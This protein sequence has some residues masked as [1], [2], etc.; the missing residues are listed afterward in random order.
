MFI[1][2]CVL[3][4]ATLAAI[5]KATNGR[6]T[7]VIIDSRNR[8]SLSKF[9]ACGWT[10]LVVAA[11]AT[12]GAFNVA[13]CREDALEFD[14]Q[15]DLLIAM[16]IS[17]VSLTATPALLSL[18]TTQQ[19]SQASL[20]SA[21]N[22]LA[23]PPDDAGTAQPATMTNNGNV[24]S[25]ISIGDA[26]LTDLFM[27]DEVG[28][29]NSP[30]LGKIQQFLITLLLLAIYAAQVFKKFYGVDFINQLPDLQ[31][32]FLWLMGVSH[33]SYLAYKAAPHS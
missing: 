11:V 9:Q 24:I 1:V 18:K 33:A 14:I 4:L 32:N 12:A 23:P 15:K 13:L 5:G 16:G 31:Q 28:N 6:W 29:Y 20:T 17:A 2:G 3:C 30:D 8:M 27:G 19:P 21:A 7:G 10:I 26:S 25:N 22:V